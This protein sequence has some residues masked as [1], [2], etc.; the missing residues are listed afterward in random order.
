MPFNLLLLP[1]LGGYLFVRGCRW[2]R[3]QAL[4]ADGHRLIFMSAL[5]GTALLTIASLIH[6]GIRYIQPGWYVSAAPL[7]HHMAPFPYSGT[8]FLSLILAAPGFMLVNI[9]RRDGKAIDSAIAERA[10]PFEMLLHRCFRERKMVAVTVKNGKVYI[11]Y[12]TVALNPAL[13][14]DSVGIFPQASGYRDAV[15]KSYKFTT[16]YMGV[17]RK[18]RTELQMKFEEERSKPDIT[19]RELLELYSRLSDDLELK[20]FEHVIPVSEIQSV[21]IF[22]PDIY[23]GHFDV[24]NLSQGSI[25]LTAPPGSSPFA[26]APRSQPS[27]P[28][29]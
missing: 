11:G 8:A 20:D 14:T 25:T 22:M 27:P 10:D 6:E 9:S 24:P 4:R 19:M 15:D 2:T 18:I 29:R 26:A 3:Y 1:L 16:D 12:V 17:Y 21:H 13:S 28:S 23:T 7:W 5:Y